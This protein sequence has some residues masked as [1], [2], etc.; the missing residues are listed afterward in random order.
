M[1][2]LIFKILAIAVF[3]GLSSIVS[4]ETVSESVAKPETV[5]VQTTEKSPSVEDNKQITKKTEEKQP[6]A[7]K[8]IENDEEEI[9]VKT[10]CV[11]DCC[12]PDCD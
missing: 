2:T 3:V 11:Y 10:R 1:K 12:P 4:A 9:K 8:E 6:E 7:V 5:Q